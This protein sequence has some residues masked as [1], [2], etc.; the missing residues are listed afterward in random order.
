MTLARYAPLSRQVKPE[1]PVC[2]GCRVPMWFDGCYRRRVRQAGLVHELTVH[3]VRCP[4]CRA[5][6]AV[7]PDFAVA[8]RLDSAEAI[9]AALALAAGAPGAE[10]ACWLFAGV[11]ARTVRSWR[12][13]F[14]AQ[15]HQLWA[16]FSALA[17]DRGWQPVNLPAGTPV[18][19]AVAAIGAAWH[20]T[21]TRCP[22]WPPRGPWRFANAMT[23]AALLAIRMGVPPARNPRC[24]GRSRSP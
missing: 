10:R 20:T 2:R 9:G 23:G 16:G 3:R 6:F 19:S 4:R 22:A 21:L 8:R 18:Q 13:R 24:R 1:R 5:G 15:G 12:A 11:P 17:A 7:L 14:A